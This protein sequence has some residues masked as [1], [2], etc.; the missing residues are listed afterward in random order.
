MSK[1][2]PYWSYD[3]WNVLFYNHLK[4]TENESKLRLSGKYSKDIDKFNNIENEALEMADD[5]SDG[6][7]RQFRL[8]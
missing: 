7:V 1:I 5:M 6:I 4:M 2:N 3:K 8:C